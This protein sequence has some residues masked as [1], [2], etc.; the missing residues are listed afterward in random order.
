[1]LSFNVY[2]L[3]G[4]AYQSRRRDLKIFRCTIVLL[5]CVVTLLSSSFVQ[6]QS[7]QRIAVLELSNRTTLSQEEVTYLSDL[8]RRLASSELAQTFLVIDKENIVTLLPPDRKLEDCVG[9]CA[10]DTGRLLSA[11]YIITGDI[12]KFGKQLRI[13]IKLHDTKTGR[14]IASEV[15]SG[16]EV[17]DMEAGIQEAGG[18]LL[19]RLMKGA[20]DTSTQGKREKIGGDY[21]S[22]GSL[23]QRVIVTLQSQPQ[24]AAVIVDG[25]QKCAEGAQTCKVEL[26][27]GA[28]Q[29]SMTKTD[30]FVRSGTVTF[31]SKNREL[32]WSLDPNFATLRVRTTPSNLTFTIN[33][34]QHQ[35]SF[36]Q[37]IAPQ[38]SYRVVSSDRCFDVR[39]E[40]VSAGKPGEEI[41]VNLAPAELLAILDVSARDQD[42]KPIEAAV[43]V[44][45]KKLGTTPHQYRVPVC[46]KELV[47]Q[48]G[49]R[50]FNQ[51][52]SMS[53]GKTFRVVA[54][55]NLVSDLDPDCDVEA[56][57]D[58]EAGTM[59]WPLTSTIASGVLGMGAVIWGF[60]KEPDVTNQDLK[61]DSFP[62]PDEHNYGCDDL[63]SEEK[64][65]ACELGRVAVGV[66]AG[67]IFVS[68]LSVFWIIMRVSSRRAA[69]AEFTEAPPKKCRS[70]TQSRKAP[71]FRL[72]Q[73]KKDSAPSPQPPLKLIPS[74]VP[75]PDG[76]TFGLGG[77]F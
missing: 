3:L 63:I 10:V 24:G 58:R 42:G 56:Y 39:G 33:G 62:S 50:T 13:T 52:L 67:A 51:T 55:L 59:L 72:S 65:Q 57:I 74:I 11:A 61:Q 26:K 68:S 4:A 60:M 70:T 16:R 29:I 18:R 22:V 43:T 44:D 14:L 34:K 17:T 23:T 36:T 32:T 9:E 41:T 8:L 46:S 54:T 53:Q 27:E 49:P 2:P 77:T 12:I 1:M 6:A 20:R 21:Q 38:K 31:T 28:H 15:A 64:A 5:A 45:G 73:G 7:E 66:G 48:N 19:R 40:K 37:R 30:Y 76:V 69:K 75:T 25:V 35:G 71:E 47:I